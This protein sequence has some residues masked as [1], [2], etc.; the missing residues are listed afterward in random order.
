MEKDSELIKATGADLDSKKDRGDN[1]D[2]IV[3]R[4][5]ENSKLQ[6]WATVL[7]ARFD[8]MIKVTKSDLANF[9][10]RQHEE[11]LS[12]PEIRLIESEMFD[13]V[14]WL[15]WAL[16]KVRQAKRQGQSLSLEDLMVKRDLIKSQTTSSSK[17]AKTRRKKSEPVP[18]PLVADE[19]DYSGLP[20]G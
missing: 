6:E 11:K 19:Q 7:N 10:I 1:V 5:S 20:E 16:A 8:G 3:L 15:N 12:D 4:C 14:R 17:G 9:L 13:E 2:R 18:P